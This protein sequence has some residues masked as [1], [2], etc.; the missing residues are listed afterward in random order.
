MG[1]I[2]WDCRRGGIADDNLD[3]RNAADKLDGIGDGIAGD[4]TDC[5]ADGIA[6]CRKR[7]GNV[8]DRCRMGSK[9]LMMANTL[10]DVRHFQNLLLPSRQNHGHPILRFRDFPI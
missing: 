5:S 1:S 2:A 3:G 7:A 10:L 4:I 9:V 8:V 6:G